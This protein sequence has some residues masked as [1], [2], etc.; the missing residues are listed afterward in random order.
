MTA[1]NHFKIIN[2][3]FGYKCLILNL[4]QGKEAVY[5]G[6]CRSNS[7]ASSSGRDAKQGCLPSATAGIKFKESVLR[8]PPLTTG[9]T[10]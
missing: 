8:V 4:Q 1:G 7:L 5:S 9:S 10:R 2:K 6:R 3:C